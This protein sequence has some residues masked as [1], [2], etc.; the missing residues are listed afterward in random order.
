MCNPCIFTAIPHAKPRLA[1]ALSGAP[2]VIQATSLSEFISVEH[3]DL[4]CALLLSFWALG[5]HPSPPRNVREMCDPFPQRS[6]KTRFV[7]DEA[8]TG[9]LIVSA[10]GR[11]WGVLAYPPPPYTASIR[12]L[13]WPPHDLTLTIHFTGS[14][15]NAEIQ[16]SSAL[17]GHLPSG[18]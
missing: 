11:I 17:L 16:W 3:T 1:L 4:G 12:V 2:L 5:S 14:A 6:A 10:K 15:K 18:P 7:L 8:Y 13:Q 9:I